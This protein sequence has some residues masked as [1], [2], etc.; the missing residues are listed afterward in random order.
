MKTTLFFAALALS[1][2]ALAQ[3]TGR[4]PA[5][6]S[7][8]QWPTF[9]SLDTNADGRLSSSEAQAS[10]SV[11]AKF[12]T[13]DK[14]GRGYVT[15]EEYQ[16]QAKMGSDRGTTSPSTPAPGAINPSTPP[17]SDSKKE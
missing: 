11:A 5:T 14:Q 9:E 12:S 2:T 16:L 15:R 3:E 10:P 17:G 13:I 8:A 4:T 6:G 1:A 7:Q